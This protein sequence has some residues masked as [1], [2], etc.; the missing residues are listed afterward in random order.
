MEADI[1]EPDDTNVRPTERPRYRFVDLIAGHVELPKWD[2]SFIY[3][4]AVGR[5]LLWTDDSQS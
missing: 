1:N 2:R 3:A 4:P 5:E